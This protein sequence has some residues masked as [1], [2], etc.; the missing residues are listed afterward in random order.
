MKDQSRQGTRAIATQGDSNPHYAGSAELWDNE[1]FL[2]R[3]NADI[4][5]KLS[6]HA[7]PGGDSLDF[8]GGIG[9]L[10]QLWTAATGSRPECVELDAR[11]HAVLGERRLTYY[12]DIDAVVKRYDV[13]YTSNVLEHIEDD[14]AVLGKLHARLKPGGI[15]AIYV[16]AFM[17]LY[18]PLDAAVGHFRRY[19]RAELRR[20]VARA[21]FDVVES[22][23]SDSLGFFAWLAF[24]FRKPQ[25]E[26]KLG[27]GTGLALY[28]RVVFPLSQL[29]DAIGARFLFGKNLVLI[30]RARG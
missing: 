11:L 16:P 23:Y 15:L 3:Y 9:T 22:Y 30:A 5:R 1:K 12:P 25:A 18:A 6:R 19:G 27:D 13:I 24:R 2:P 20:K 28:D 7:P 29:L 17:C 4:V 10:A 21:N 8:G 26:H 14:V